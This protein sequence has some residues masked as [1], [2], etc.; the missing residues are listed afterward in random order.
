MT[1]DDKQQLL[2]YQ[3]A[4]ETLPQY[5][6]LGKIDKLTFFYLNENKKMSFVGT[7]KD[8]EKLETK[9]FDAM[10][11]IQKEDFKATPNKHVCQY[12]DFKEICEFR[13]L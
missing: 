2:I 1:I 7:D 3:I 10:E 9:L 5:Q 4:V 8:K 11:R 6:N 12:C 13:Q